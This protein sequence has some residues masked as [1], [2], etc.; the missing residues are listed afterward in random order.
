MGASSSKTAVAPILPA[1]QLS[2]TQ[3]AEA[4]KALGGPYVGYAEKLEEN[5]MDGVFL[6]ETSADDPSFSKNGKWKTENKPLQH[7]L[8]TCDMWH[9][10][11]VLLYVCASCAHARTRGRIRDQTQTAGRMQGDAG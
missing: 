2:A 11:S 3:V 1:S 5:G 10:V 4:V 7:A 6:E 8:W 9:H